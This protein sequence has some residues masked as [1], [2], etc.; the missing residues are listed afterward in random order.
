MAPTL[1]QL[2]HSRFAIDALKKMGFRQIQDRPYEFLGMVKSQ[3]SEHDM[4]AL[5]TIV[6]LRLQQGN[7]VISLEMNGEVMVKTRMAT[8]EDVANIV[9]YAGVVKEVL[10]LVRKKEN[11]DNEN[12]GNQ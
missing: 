5:L 2:N 6:P 12:P 11:D 8:L 4:A 1:K 10:T 7:Y 3:H 9:G